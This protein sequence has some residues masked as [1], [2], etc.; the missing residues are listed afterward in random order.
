MVQHPPHIDKRGIHSGYPLEFHLVN[1]LQLECNDLSGG[2]L[3][4]LEGRFITMVTWGI[5]EGLGEI[6][7][8][9]GIVGFQGKPD[10]F[11]VTGP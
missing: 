3:S 1:W 2:S 11:C 10:L 8:P 9:G 7:A 6:V 4:C 5:R